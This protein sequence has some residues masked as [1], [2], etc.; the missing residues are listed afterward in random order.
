MAKL[1]A[2]GRPLSTNIST[3]RLCRVSETSVPDGHHG[4]APVTSASGRTKKQTWKRRVSIGHR[5][6]LHSRD[7]P[8][9]RKTVKRVRQTDAFAAN[10]EDVSDPGW[11]STSANGGVCRQQ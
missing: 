7:V 2:L 3:I 10:S 9:A 5:Q 4:K 11:N 8:S 6:R 1:C